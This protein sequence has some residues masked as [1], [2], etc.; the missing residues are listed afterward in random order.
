MLFLNWVLYKYNLTKLPTFSSVTYIGGPRFLQQP[1][2]CQLGPHVAAQFHLVRFIMWSQHL[3]WH[4]V[5]QRAM[6]LG[7]YSN[8]PSLT[9][10]LL[11]TRGHSTSKSHQRSQL[12]KRGRA[13]KI[14]PFSSS[15]V[16][17]SS[18]RLSNASSLTLSLLGFR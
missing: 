3:S 9:P 18:R 14:F 16:Q 11:F 4:V 17:S 10:S 15:G 8:S 2:R 13:A 1:K 6:C 7:R 5:V 12:H